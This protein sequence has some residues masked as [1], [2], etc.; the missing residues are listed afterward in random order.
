[1]N[2]LVLPI[3]IIAVTFL[4]FS[5]KPDAGKSGS[6][7][8]APTS[9]LKFEEKTLLKTYKDCDPQNEN[10]TYIQIKYSLINQGQHKDL[11]NSAITDFIISAG[12]P[13]KK[14][15]ENLTIEQIADKFINEYEIFL[16]ENK[17]YNLGWMTEIQGKPEFSNTKIICYSISNVYFLGGAHPNSNLTYLNFERENGRLVFIP[18]IFSPGFEEKLN[19]A[20][21]SE[22]RKSRNISPEDGLTDKAGLFNNKISYNNNFAVLREGIRFYY[23]PYEIA[24]YAAGPIEVTVPYEIIKDIIPENSPIN[25]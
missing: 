5:C 24:P 9:E 12:E 14:S 22:F 6:N 16:N 4:I 11:I 25:F 21:D 3:F 7:I 23:N 17:D 10:C 8:S 20:V 19:Q 2:K 15:M 1:M 18:D 13:G